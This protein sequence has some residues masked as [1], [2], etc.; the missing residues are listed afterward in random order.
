MMSSSLS[1]S[2]DL[3]ELAASLH[4]SFHRPELLQQALTHSSFANEHPN[5]SASASDHYSDSDSDNEQLEFLGDAV[6]SIVTSEYLFR[7]FP[8]YSEGELSKLRAHL[9]SSRHLVKA[10]RA[11]HLGE[12]IRLGRGEERSGG[13]SKQVVLADCIEALIAALYLDGGI[14]AARRFILPAIITPELERMGADPAARTAGTDFKSTLQ[15]LLQAH[16]RPQPSYHV[17]AQSG[18]EHK[19]IFTIELQLDA[20]YTVKAEG[21][22]KKHAEQRAAELALAHLRTHPIEDAP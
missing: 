21:P 1:L 7:Q 9:V 8:N 17:V 16:G 15:E 4:H 20:A 3:L 14:E 13:R 12:Y 2:S 19:K 6:L 11:L 10:A 18:P 5:G 22:S